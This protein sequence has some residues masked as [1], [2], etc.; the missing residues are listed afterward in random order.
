MLLLLPFGNTQ[1]GKKRGEERGKKSK[2]AVLFWGGLPARRG[3]KGEKGGGKEKNRFNLGL[4]FVVFPSHGLVGW[5]MNEGG[6]GEKE[7]KGGGG[8]VKKKVVF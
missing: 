7:K 5:A 3:E 1:G 2:A 6:G 8:D 4:D